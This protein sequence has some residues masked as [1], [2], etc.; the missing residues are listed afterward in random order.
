M[1]VLVFPNK[2]IPNLLETG[3]RFWTCREISHPPLNH[4][5]RPHLKHE[6]KSKT[7][8]GMGDR[9]M[10]TVRRE[11]RKKEIKEMGESLDALNTLLDEKN[12]TIEN[13]FLKNF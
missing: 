4:Q 11:N 8:C 6:K 3:S 13:I 7:N 5:E 1:F 2:N 10:S 9:V 12:H